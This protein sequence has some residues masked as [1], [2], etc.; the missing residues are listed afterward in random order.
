M[1][2]IHCHCLPAVDDGAGD[3]QESIALV[4]FAAKD[5]IR[6]LVL[7]PHVYAGRW[8]NTLATLRPRFAAFSKLIASKGIPV[9]LYLGAEVHLLPEIFELI[10]QGEVPYVGGWEGEPALL[11]ELHDGRIP[12]FAISAVRHLRRQGIRPIIAHPERN[13]AVMADVAC[14]EPFIGEDCLMQV[15]AGSISGRF[16]AK[17][18]ATA[19][20]LLDRQW[21]HFVASDAHNLQHRPPAMRAARKLLAERIAKPLADELTIHAPG[22]LIDGRAALGL[23]RA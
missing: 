14:L 9:E 15:T 21:A 18:E 17:A 23:D 20:A 10:E 7:T 11:L 3:I 4:R 1:N 16:G 6:R 2:D 5:G 13:R 22:A 19:F 8:D 12:P